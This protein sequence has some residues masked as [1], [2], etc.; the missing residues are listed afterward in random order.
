[1]ERPTTEKRL[2]M[3]EHYLIPTGGQSVQLR[4]QSKIALL[5]GAAVDSV[6]P[7][8]LPLLDGSLTA[9][10]V[11]QQGSERCG[12]A[13]IRAVLK[14]LGQ[15]GF[16]EEVD[17]PA[18]AARWSAFETVGRW[19]QAGVFEGAGAH[20]LTELG[21]ATVAL[22]G[23]G[24]AAAAIAAG[25]R[26]IGIG[27]V[28]PVDR[29]EQAGELL[30]RVALSIVCADRPAV[31]DDRLRAFNA[32]AVDAGTPWLAVAAVA[33][34]VVQLGPAIFPGMTACLECLRLQFERNTSFLRA[35]GLIDLLCGAPGPDPGAARS[36]ELAAGALVIEAARALVTS[37]Q[38][39]ISTARILTLD[40]DRFELDRY[41]VHKIPRCPVCG[42][43]RN[44]PPMRIWG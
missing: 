14:L 32:T 3:R 19:F 4:S 6:L 7:Q 25:L 33:P 2:R 9:A 35:A 41:Q 36:L 13:K 22:A 11:V 16:L 38:N 10:Q 43:A 34:G 21:Q 20:A 27:Q 44:R 17:P 12:A 8:V 1:M 26:S 29:P 30:G 39:P 18:D 31:F 40:L 15:E 37:G 42:P 28:L 5:R 23:A 24:P